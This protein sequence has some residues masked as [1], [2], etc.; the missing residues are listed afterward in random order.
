MTGSQGQGQGLSS[1]F[2]L[3]ESY[4]LYTSTCVVSVLHFPVSYYRPLKR[5]R[6]SHNSITNPLSIT[7]VLLTEPTIRMNVRIVGSVLAVTATV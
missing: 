7:A 2:Y 3:Q 5:L 6:S 4:S 1:L